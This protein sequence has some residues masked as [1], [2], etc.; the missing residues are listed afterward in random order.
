ALPAVFLGKDP[1]AEADVRK[2]LRV[3]K[4][5]P[6]KMAAAELA[7]RPLRDFEWVRVFVLGKMSE[8]EG[9][10]LRKHFSH[11]SD[12]VVVAKPDDLTGWIEKLAFKKVGELSACN[13]DL[14]EFVPI[15]RG[16]V[17][18]E[19][20]EI[21]GPPKWPRRVRRDVALMFVAVLL[22]FAISVVFPGKTRGKRAYRLVYP[23]LSALVLTFMA[24]WRIS[25]PAESVSLFEGRQPDGGGSARK[26]VETKVIS[27]AVLERGGRG[28]QVRDLLAVP[29][30]VTPVASHPRQWVEHRLVL[31]RMGELERGTPLGFRDVSVRHWYG[32]IPGRLIFNLLMG[33]DYVCVVEVPPRRRL[34]FERPSSRQTIRPFSE[35]LA[36]RHHPDARVEELRDGMLRY[37]YSHRRQKG[38]AYNVAWTEAS[39]EGEVFDAGVMVVIKAG[40]CVERWKPPR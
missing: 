28:A 10:Q 13:A 2:V 4:I 40:H 25:N 33:G 37:W 8:S 31:T 9:T 38:I 18:P 29:Q 16:S 6:I 35:Y 27:K 34:P 5:F 15:P 30:R 24:S 17:R 26:G 14:A 1:P 20:Y 23:V 36:E 3:E 12:S 21:F 39:T 19:L 32:R 22:V 7:D 11:L